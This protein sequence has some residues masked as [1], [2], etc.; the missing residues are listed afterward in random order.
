MKFRERYLT[1][2]TAPTASAGAS[3]KPAS[4][5]PVGD[6]LADKPAPEKASM[7]SVDKSNTN[8]NQPNNTTE[9]QPNQPE[10]LNNGNFTQSVMAFQKDS[11]DDTFN[12]LN[13]KERMI[14]RFVRLKNQ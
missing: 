14:N 4:N 5:S 11:K 6:V 3:P 2:V 7:E 8:I 10:S 9:N 12:D 13:A 1:E